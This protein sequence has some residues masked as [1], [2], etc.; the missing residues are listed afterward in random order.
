MYVYEY[1]HEIY[2]YVYVY[3]Y[4]YLCIFMYAHLCS[5]DVPE[6]IKGLMTSGYSHCSI[7]QTWADIVGSPDS[8]KRY[9]SGGLGKRM[10]PGE[11]HVWLCDGYDLCHGVLS[12]EDMMCYVFNERLGTFLSMGPNS[13][14]KFV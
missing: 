1:V 2:I 10:V 4:I 3:I 6:I 14:V 11:Y 8:R 5:V 7:E 13:K 12:G 9:R